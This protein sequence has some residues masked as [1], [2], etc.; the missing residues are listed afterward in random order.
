VTT[1]AAVMVTFNRLARL[2]DSLARVLSEPLARV[3]VVDNASTDGTG[4]W[5]AGVQD[6]RLTVLRL[7]DNMGGAG[8]FAAGM[9]AL[10]DMDPDWI[11][12]L[13]DDAWP[14][15]GAVSAFAE[16]VFP[17]DIGAVAA[18]VRLPDGRI[19][20][21]NRP[22]FNPFWRMAA[23]LGAFLGAFRR[24]KRAGFK[25]PDA[26]YD[27]TAPVQM[28]DNAS[29]VGYFVSRAGRA[30]VGVPE[31]GLFIYGDDVLY[32]LTLRRAGLQIAFAPQVRFTHDCGTMGAGFIYRPLWKAYYHCRNGV[33]IARAAAGPVVFP[34]ALA[35][36]MA[37]WARRGRHYGGAERR[38]YRRMMWRGVWDGLLGRRGRNDRIHDL[39]GRLAPHLAPH[40]AP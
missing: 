39:A 27:P 8:G 4:D 9:A 25:L 6:P 29:F 35:Y 21:M 17:P 20:E 2:Q 23:F 24:G 31:A 18:A 19:A 37:V 36:Y 13:D 12:L 1:V 26:A 5:L 11:L 32:S 22:G 33:A 14:E 3:L 7:P 16:T 10:A 28:I 30:A 38:L 34:L 40:L 15:P